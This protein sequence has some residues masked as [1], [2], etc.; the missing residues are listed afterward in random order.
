MRTYFRHRGVGTHQGQERREEREKKGM[1]RWK[2]KDRGT[3]GETPHPIPGNWCAHRKWRKDGKKEKRTKKQ[4]AGLQPCYPGPF[5]HLLRPAGIIRWAYFCNNLGPRGKNKYIYI[6]LKEY[7]QQAALKGTISLGV[8]RRENRGKRGKAGVKRKWWVLAQSPY[9]P[10]GQG[11]RQSPRVEPW[12]QGD[13][14]PDAE[15]KWKREWGRIPDSF[16]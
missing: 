8:R 10:Q 16:T 5:D 13:R 4:G 2:K 7:L 3:K 14:Q 1:K 6:L 15:E 11:R 12:I 9:S